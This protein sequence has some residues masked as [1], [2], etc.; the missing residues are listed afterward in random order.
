[1]PIKFVLLVAGSLISV[2][3]QV[4]LKLISPHMPTSWQAA[5]DLGMLKSAILFLRAALFSGMSLLMT[6]YCYKYF[7][8]LEFIL[9]STL[10]YLFA[11]LVS[12]YYFGEPITVNKMISMFLILAGIAFLYAK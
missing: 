8:F 12:H 11:V 2:I 1:M 5:V 9:A 3:A 6:L 4:N 7:E 10:T